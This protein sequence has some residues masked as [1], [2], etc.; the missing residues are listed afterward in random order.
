MYMPKVLSGV[1]VHKGRVWELS[2]HSGV[3]QGPHQQCVLLLCAGAT[4]SP[5]TGCWQ[6]WR[7]S[8]TLVGQTG[9]QPS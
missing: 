2:R 8:Q 7:G 6:G 1:Q 4:P 5:L 9:C 3:V